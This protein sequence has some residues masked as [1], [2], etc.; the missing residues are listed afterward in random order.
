MYRYAVKY[1]H[2]NGN[3]NVPVKFKADDGMNLYE[4]LQM[5]KKACKQ[6]KL[7]EE[8]ISKLNTIGIAL[9]ETI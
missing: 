6:G 2:E 1:F 7:S 9:R 3:L 4:W 8:Q 5:Q